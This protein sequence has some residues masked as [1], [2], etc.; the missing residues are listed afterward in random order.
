MYV[1]YAENPQEFKKT[2]RKGDMHH[3]MKIARCSYFV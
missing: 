2:Y 1:H 3:N